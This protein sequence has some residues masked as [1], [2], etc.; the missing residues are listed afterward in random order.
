MLRRC[1]KELVVDRIRGRKT[2]EAVLT[3]TKVDGGHGGMERAALY[4]LVDGTK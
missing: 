3:S 2:K 4:H 1:L